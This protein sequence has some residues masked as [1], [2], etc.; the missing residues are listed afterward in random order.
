M[1]PIDVCVIA[2][3]LWTDL[4]DL[5]PSFSSVLVFSSSVSGIFFVWSSSL[6]VDGCY[7]RCSIS[8]CVSTKTPRL[9]L[10]DLNIISYVH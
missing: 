5:N 6:I 3:Y 7:G 8:T 10:S 4:M 2:Q 1:F 9:G